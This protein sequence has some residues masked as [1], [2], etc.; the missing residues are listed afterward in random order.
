MGTPQEKRDYELH[1]NTIIAPVDGEG[2]TVG[3]EGMDSAAYSQ[4]IA[5]TKEFYRNEHQCGEEHKRDGTHLTGL[6]YHFMRS[7]LCF[8]K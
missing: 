8:L 7:T 5:V 1:K 2:I 4:V 6:L 3:K